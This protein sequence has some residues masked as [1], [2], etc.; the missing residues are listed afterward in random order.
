[1]SPEEHA[2]ARSRA[3]GL[4][5]GLWTEGLTPSRLEAVRQTPLAAHLPEPLDVDRLQA[6]HHQAWT[7]EV[8]PYAGVFLDTEEG[9]GGAAQRLLTDCRAAGFSP[10]TDASRSDHIG[11]ALAALS[12]LCGAE[13]DALQDGRT[14]I[15][16]GIVELQHGILDRHLLSWLPPLLVSGRGVV[17]GFWGEVLELTAALLLEH[18]GVAEAAWSPPELSEGL[19]EERKTSLWRIAGVLASPALSGVFLTRADLGG[20]GRAADVPR[21]FGARQQQ[22]A[23]LLR[24]AAEYEQLPAIIDQLDVLWKARAEAY[25]ALSEQH[26]ELAPVTEQWSAQAE[27]LRALLTRFRA[28]I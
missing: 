9:L 26:P 24:N 4:L 3:Y 7:L 10:K 25:A 11:V 12:M 17:G 15:A 28:A 20:I 18:R 19:L 13:A 5:A 27:R 1:M 21:G 16:S 22:L 2:E 23:N 6:T 14:D 8:L